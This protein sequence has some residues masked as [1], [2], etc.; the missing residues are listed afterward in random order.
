M[1]AQRTAEVESG[2]VELIPWSEAK[3]RARNALGG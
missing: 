3:G 2:T 1:I